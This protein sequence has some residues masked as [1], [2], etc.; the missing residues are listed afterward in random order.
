[1]SRLKLFRARDDYHRHFTVL[2]IGTDLIKVLVVRREG[3]AGAVL[4]TSREPQAGGAMEQGAIADVERVTEACNRALEAAEDMAGVVP[5]QAVVGI[6]GELV[7]AFSSAIVYPRPRP[8]QRLRESELRSTLQL[9]ERR[10]LRE[11]QHLLELEGANAPTEGRLVQS[12][13][14]QVRIDGSP[15]ANPL[16]QPGKSL[17]VTVFN[18]FAP[19]AQVEAVE[20][21]A[22]ELDLELTEIVAQ[23]YALARATATEEDWA[24]GAL[25]VDVG[26][27]STDVALVRG[28]VVESTRMF[29]LGGRS[30]TRR[31]SQTMA[32]SF[33]EAEARKI[34]HSDGLL[35][36]DR[37]REVSAIL[38][39]DVEVLLQG[40]SLCLEELAQGE[41]LPDA[42]Y[43]CGGG[44]L[45]P[46]LV[47]DLL[48][49][50][51]REG[52]PFASEPRVRRLAPSDVQ[53][54]SDTTG[55]LTSAQDVGPLSLA[56]H[57]LQTGADERL[58]LN[59]LMQGVLKTIK[60]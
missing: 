9:V 35:P 29:A 14:T 27:G 10:A 49:G 37:D 18:T 52:L 26:G 60:M 41:A 21:L 22:R 25:Y 2:D 4:G 24:T 16:G 12:T 11:G 50:D 30:F 44:S 20:T 51:W 13:V 53:G 56:S 32:C 38:A 36:P 5:G 1:L 6:G 40:L 33:D 57:F 54:V 31:L 39:A 55:L 42:L 59:A 28:G 23:P 58:Q 48:A 47:S 7:K 17:E 19:L 8:D 45:L 43:V 15:V 46:E 3:A 34:R